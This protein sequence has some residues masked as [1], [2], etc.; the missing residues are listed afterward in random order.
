MAIRFANG[1]VMVDT[2]PGKRIQGGYPEN[3]GYVCLQ[4]A[5][6]VAVYPARAEHRCEEGEGRD[7]DSNEEISNC[8]G[9]KEIFVHERQ[10]F[11]L[12]QHQ[13]DEDVGKNDRKHEH[14]N[15]ERFERER[16]IVIVVVSP[17]VC[18]GGVC[19]RRSRR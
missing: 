11:C 12:V 17:V 10:L 3:G 1:H 14:E 18:G 7:E 13:Q 6:H 16:H 9:G 19:D 15:H 8:E 5:E 4:M 2:Y